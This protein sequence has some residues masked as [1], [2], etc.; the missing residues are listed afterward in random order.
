MRNFYVESIYTV[1]TGVFMAT[2]LELAITAIR[3]NRKDEGRQLLNLL[4]QENPNDEK[5][6][7][8]MSSVVD[9]DEQRARCLYHV[10]AINPENHNARRGL[11]LLGIVVSDSRPVKLPRDSQPIQIPKPVPPNTS[12]V[13]TDTQPLKPIPQPQTATVAAQER[14]PF[15]LDPQEVV[16]ELPFK[17]I[18]KPF[19]TTSQT[20]DAA[21]ESANPSEPVPVVAQANVAEPVTPLQQ[22]TP[23]KPQPVLHTENTLPNNGQ[24][25]T[26]PDPSEP[27]PAVQPNTIPNPIVQQSPAQAFPQ[28][29]PDSN[30]VPVTPQPAPQQ[31]GQ[32]Q[33]YPQ[34]QPGVQAPVQDTRPSQPVPIQQNPSQP[35]PVVHSNA[36]MGMPA[37]QSQIPGQSQPVAPIHTNATTMM[38]APQ[39]VNPSEPVPVVHSNVTMGMPPPQQQPQVQQQYANNYAAHSNSTTMMPIGT[40]PFAMTGPNQAAMVDYRVANA[41]GMSAPGTNQTK[42]NDEEEDE[43][44]VL[45]VVIF[46][47]LSVTALGGLGMLILLMFA[48]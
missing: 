26:V 4:I 13:P 42:D 35:V 27:V 22:Q 36:T 15:R 10:L 5:A 14:R 33:F 6:W 18:T 34:Q 21:K 1:K 40:N 20:T 23:S 38:P 24:S 12:F 2:S 32:G 8:W 30:P 29:N 7:L 44:N 9:T 39:A 31:M 45:A 11:Q 41:V 19:T 43:I 46:G 3:S 25:G 17:P 28:T 47:S 37:Q 48:T 16:N